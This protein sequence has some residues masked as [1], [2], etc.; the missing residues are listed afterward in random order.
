MYRAYKARNRDLWLS[1]GSV[2][3]GGIDPSALADSACF[4]FPLAVFG[5]GFAVPLGDVDWRELRS[6]VEGRKTAAQR[7]YS[8]QSKYDLARRYFEN[9]WDSRRASSGSGLEE[10]TEGG[11]PDGSASCIGESGSVLKDP[12][13]EGGS[14]KEIESSA[15]LISVRL[16]GDNV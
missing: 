8:R 16:T 3:S 15:A 2:L 12:V 6:R 10:K 5:E 14:G 11:G 4:D 9:S 1:S 7:S 13:S